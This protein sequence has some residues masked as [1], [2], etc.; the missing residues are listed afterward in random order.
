MFYCFV[1]KKEIH[2]KKIRRKLSSLSITILSKYLVKHMLN[3]KKKIVFNLSYLHSNIKVF[4]IVL[5]GTFVRY[6]CGFYFYW[7]CYYKIIFFM[8][9]NSNLKRKCLHY[10]DFFSVI[11]VVFGN[12]VFQHFLKN[13][14]GY[15]LRALLA[16]LSMYSYEAEFIQKLAREKKNITR[17]GLQLDIKVY[18]R[19]IIK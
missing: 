2:H 8:R 14:Y 13:F 4:L 12:Q 10:H 17:C 1:I 15:Q 7:F 6:F 16:D 18:R 11:C 5:I 3:G 19:H 9:K